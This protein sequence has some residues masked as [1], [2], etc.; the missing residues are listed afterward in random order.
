[1]PLAS[2]RSSRSWLQR[3]VRRGGSLRAPPVLR[4]SKAR[5]SLGAQYV[6]EKDQQH[7]GEGLDVVQRIVMKR[8]RVAMEQQRAEVQDREDGQAARRL[9]R[10]KD[11]G[12][13]KQETTEQIK[14]NKRCTNV[15]QT[16]ISVG[17]VRVAS[18]WSCQTCLRGGIATAVDEMERMASSR[19]GRWKE[20]VELCTPHIIRQYRTRMLSVVL[21][22]IASLAAAAAAPARRG[23]RQASPPAR[24]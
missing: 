15:F 23:G 7:V 2:R 8:S 20:H 1:M 12:Q 6:R 19:V 22:R 18:R 16:S 17:A 3:V 21:L 9:R 11:G 14:S 4:L 24:R 10:E 13:G 5:E